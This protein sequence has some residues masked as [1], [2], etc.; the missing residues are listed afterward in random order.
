M[1][2]ILL[3]PGFETVEALAPADVLRRGGVPVALTGIG[4]LT[5]TSAQSVPVVCDVAVEE[6]ALTEGDMVVLPGGL[7]GVAA[8]EGCEEAM[9]LVR[10]AAGN[11]DMWL[12]AICAAPAMLA[13]QGVLGSG[14]DGV[15]YPGMEGEMI[16]AGV[17]PHMDASVVV[18]GSL[19]TGRAPGSAID[20]ALTLLEALRGEE[21]AAKVCGDLHYGL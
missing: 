4:G 5:V 21:A 17:T 13:R 15:C 7:G 2:Y 3:G 1:V 11:E 16:A 9:A 12:A 18:D 6:V 20:F 10:T 19:I 8:I 14:D